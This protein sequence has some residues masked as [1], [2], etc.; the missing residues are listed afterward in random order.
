[1]WNNV[2][3]YWSSQ[4][5]SVKVDPYLTISIHSLVLDVQW[6]S[7]VQT[8]IGDYLI[9]KSGRGGGSGAE[10]GRPS[11][12]WQMTHCLRTCLTNRLPLTIQNLV[13]ISVKIS[14]TSLCNTLLW[15]SLTISSVI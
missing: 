8:H 3:M 15:A 9:L 7:E 6:A 5:E 4:T 10:D 12:L 2:Q 14:F 11:D 1:M 13:L